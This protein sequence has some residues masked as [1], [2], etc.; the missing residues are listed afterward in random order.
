VRTRSGNARGGVRAGI[1]I[2][3]AVAAMAGTLAPAAAA[4][5]AAAATTATQNVF[6]GAPAISSWGWNPS[7]EN[8]DGTTT[9]KAT[10]EPVLGLPSSHGLQVRAIQLASSPLAQTNAALLTNGTVWAWGRNSFGELGDGTTTDRHTA[11][12]VAGLTGITQIALGTF[13]MMAV[14]AGGTVWSWGNNDYGQLGNGTTTSRDV[15][16]QVPGLTGVTQLAGGA[17]YSLAL[18]SNGTVLAWGDNSGGQLGDGTTTSRDVPGQVPGLTGI[19]QVAAADRTSYA[20]RSDG[21]LLAWGSGY[22]GNGQTATTTP[23]AVPLAGVTQVATSG[24]DTLAIVGSSGQVW[25]WGINLSGEIGDGTANVPRT[26]PV[27]INLSGIT[28]VSEGLDASMAVRSDGSLFA[29]GANSLFNLGLGG[30]VGYALVPTLVSYLTNVTMVAEGHEGGIAAG[31]Y[32]AA[33]IPSVI[34]DTQSEASTALQAAG[35]ALGRVSQVVDITCEFIG[36]VKTQSPAAGTLARLG[37][38][39]NVAIG[40]PGGKCL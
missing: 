12:Q 10:P 1:T 35:F 9:P 6:P 8:G 30:S 21:T 13:H 31:Q 39:V 22:L 5:Q 40:K 26:S 29:W 24:G 20:L 27:K 34:G 36:E 11:V 38:S 15:P 23:V 19:I 3:A 2:A 17:N 25:S 18:R 32:D 28:Q 37:T 33:T 7:G 4:T 16:G 14:G